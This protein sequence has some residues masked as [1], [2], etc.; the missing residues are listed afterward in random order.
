MLKAPD[1]DKLTG[2]VRRV[3]GVEEADDIDEA[4]AADE[5]HLCEDLVAQLEVPCS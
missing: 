3:C 2:C 1:M 4:D 5:S